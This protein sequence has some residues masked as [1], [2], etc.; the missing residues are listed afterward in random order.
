[1]YGFPVIQIRKNPH[2]AQ[3]RANLGAPSFGCVVILEIKHSLILLLAD[4]LSLT[5]EWREPFE[6]ASVC[7]RLIDVRLLDC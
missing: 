1:M 7:D 4:R 5:L 2:S 6:C 3:L